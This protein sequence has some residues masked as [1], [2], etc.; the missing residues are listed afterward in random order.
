MLASVNTDSAEKDQCILYT[1]IIA[2][3]GEKV[4]LNQY[5]GIRH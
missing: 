4:N 3:Q 2:Q 5:R 1:E